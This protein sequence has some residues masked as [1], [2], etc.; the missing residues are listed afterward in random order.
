MK[1]FLIAFSVFIVWSFFGLW[2]YSWFEAEEIKVNDASELAENTANDSTKNIIENG[3]L[4]EIN[5]EEAMILTEDSISTIENIVEDFTVDYAFKAINEEGDV[6]F[7][8]SVGTS[9]KQ[10]SPE[11]FIPKEAIDYKYKINS[12]LIEHPN[13]EVQINSLYGASENFDS[14]NLGV[15]R[16]EKIKAELIEVGI[17]ATRIVIKPVIKGIDFDENGVYKNGIS[18]AFKPL[19]EAR[20]KDLKNKLPEPKIVYPNFSN[21]GILINKNLKN[22]FTEVKELVENNPDLRVEIIGHTDNIGNSIDNYKMGLN[23][24]RQVHWY[25]TAKGAIKKSNIKS[26]SKGEEEPIDT[27]KSERGRMANRRIEVIFY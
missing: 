24:A 23:Y 13:K 26:T 9:F 20:I 5:L 16:G 4:P 22:L 7:K 15:Q 1:N 8:Y 25:L 27:N 11:V 3:E 21:S 14:P 19:N 18:F 17:P 6:I 12:Y 2:L 10:N